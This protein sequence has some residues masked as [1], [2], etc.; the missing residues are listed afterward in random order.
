M[1]KVKL[2]LV[3]EKMI[4]QQ[5]DR[6][7]ALALVKQRAD[8]CLL[9]TEFGWVKVFKYQMLNIIEGMKEEAIE[10]AKVPHFTTYR[11]KRIALPIDKNT[12]TS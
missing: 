5:L 4:P 7:T 12:P 1:A 3:F 2:D 11:F 10:V 9:W 8:C 6:E